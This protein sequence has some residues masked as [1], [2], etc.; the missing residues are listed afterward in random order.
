MNGDGCVHW[1]IT[2]SLSAGTHTITVSYTDSVNTNVLSLPLVITVNAGTTVAGVD[3]WQH[4]QFP[5]GSDFSCDANPYSG[6]TSGYFTYSYDGGT[7]V[8]VVTNAGGHAL[9]KVTKPTIGTHTVTVNYPA[10]GNYGA[11]ALPVQTFVVTG[12]PVYVALTPSTWYTQTGNA[13]SFNVALSSWSAGAPGSLGTVSFYDGS[14][15][16][17]TVPVNATGNASF[18]TSALTAGSHTVTANYSG[19]ATQYAA[20]SNAVTIQIVAKTTPTIMT[21]PAPSALTFGQALGSASLNGGLSSTSG[22]FAWTLPL[23]VPKA[24]TGSYSVTFTP[25]DT[26]NFSTVISFVTITIS[27]LTPKITT[28][29][30]GSALSFGQTLA[31]SVLGG[32]LASTPGS[33]AWTLPAT[34]PP[35]GTTSYSVIFTPTDAI[36]Y[37]TVTYSVSVVVN[38]I[39]PT[40]ANVP[41]A[42]TLIVGQTLGSSPL[43][44]G[45]ASIPGTFA[46]T[47]P[48]TIPTAGT[49]NY[50]VTFTPTDTTHYSTSISF[51]SITVNKIVPTIASVPAATT[52]IAGQTLGSSP[53]TGGAASIP[54][55]FAWTSPS[56]IPTA[57]TANYSVTFTPT[58]TTRYSTSIS[59]ISITVNKTASTISSVPTASSIVPGQTL[60]S[61]PLTGGSASIPG[62]FA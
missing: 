48:S 29:S 14:T 52:L 22:R 7:P 59:Y 45:S 3:C 42:T 43:T 53:L 6:P 33:F 39:V 31:S 26:T 11:Y 23:T 15:S 51:I 18:S 50:S 38:K 34:V 49:A 54:G 44:G 62:T 58:D 19:N 40:I 12:A 17:A 8:Q 41:A 10:Q 46:W 4:G 60:G 25:S 5:Y 21:K 13:V 16:L 1:Y 27:K 30:T 32:G 24:G 57:G 35:L 36:D 56:I 28:T 20:A 55:T 61:S 9:Y 47:S 2:P 37:N